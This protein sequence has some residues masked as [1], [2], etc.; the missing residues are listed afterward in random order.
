MV[1]FYLNATF[2]IAFKYKEKKKKEVFV[3]Y[4]HFLTSFSPQN[5]GFWC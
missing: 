3:K 2:Y 5:S 1:Q 4:E